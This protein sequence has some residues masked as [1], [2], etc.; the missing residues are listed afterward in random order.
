MNRGA[1]GRAEGVLVH[2]L[3]PVPTAPALPRCNEI[4]RQAIH[5]GRDP[6]IRDV[7]SQLPG[8]RRD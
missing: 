4:T 6:F 2:V 7:Q 3:L 5:F 8:E 1:A